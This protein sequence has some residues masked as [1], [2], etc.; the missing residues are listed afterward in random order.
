MFEGDVKFVTSQ[1]VR[2]L[3]IAVK[4]YQGKYR[5]ETKDMWDCLAETKQSPSGIRYKQPVGKPVRIKEGLDA[6]MQ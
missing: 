3:S 4:T 5:L 1:W 6:L 2:E